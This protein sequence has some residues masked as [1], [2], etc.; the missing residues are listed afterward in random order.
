MFSHLVQV[1]MRHHRLH[2]S[3]VWLV[4]LLYVELGKH[5]LM[6]TCLFNTM[7]VACVTWWS[8][9]YLM[10]LLRAETYPFMI[11]CLSDTQE[12]N[13]FLNY[14]VSCLLTLPQYMRQGYGK[15]LIDFSEYLSLVFFFFFWKCNI[16]P[17]LSIGWLSDISV[18]GSRR[19]TPHGAGKLLQTLLFYRRSLGDV[20]ITSLSLSLVWQYRWFVCRQVRFVSVLWCTPCGHRGFGCVFDVL[21]LQ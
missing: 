20:W 13:S 6:I 5:H 3:L 10:P 4:S 19:T 1:G 8:L 2:V 9:N 11:T 16:L 15:M 12:K 7:I 17:F 18:Y 21:S 14:N